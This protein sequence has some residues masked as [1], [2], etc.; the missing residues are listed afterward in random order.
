MHISTHGFVD[1][2]MCSSNNTLRFYFFATEFDYFQTK[3]K[4]CSQIYAVSRTHSHLSLF[5]FRF[6]TPGLPKSISVKKMTSP[7]ECEF[8]SKAFLQQFIGLKC[9]DTS[10]FHCHLFSVN[11]RHKVGVSAIK[12][13]LIEQV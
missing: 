6:S 8:V 5:V 7:F 9:S 4:I 13:F 10:H 11:D 2:S 1:F 12:P 3:H